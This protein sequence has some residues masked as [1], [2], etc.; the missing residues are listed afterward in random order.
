[1]RNNC[2]S[3]RG[4]LPCG[5][6]GKQFPGHILSFFQFLRD[7]NSMC[8]VP[9]LH[10]IVQYYLICRCKTAHPPAG[11]I[12]HPCLQLVNKGLGLDAARPHYSI[13]AIHLAAGPEGLTKP[14][15]KIWREDP[16]GT[17][18]P[19]SALPASANMQPS[20]YLESACIYS[21]CLLLEP[22]QH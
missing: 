6:M 19:C 7:K 16:W 9:E 13:S 5:G 15:H 22:K 11:A 14:F 4:R 2:H 20:S 18:W 12:P 3:S 1:M 21:Y 8:R 17:T 10:Y